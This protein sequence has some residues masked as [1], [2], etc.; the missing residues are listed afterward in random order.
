VVEDVDGAALPPPPESHAEHASTS[1]VSD[2]RRM[3]VRLPIGA[4]NMPGDKARVSSQS[5]S[6]TVRVEP[7]SKDVRRAIGVATGRKQWFGTLVMLL[8]LAGAIAIGAVLFGPAGPLIGALAFGACF[9]S[10]IL[11]SRRKMKRQ[12]ERARRGLTYTVDASGLRSETPDARAEF[13]W[14]SFRSAQLTD[15]H[16][17]LKLA[18]SG[19]VIYVPRRCFES[20]EA[21]STFIDI[22]SE[23][24]PVK[25][26]GKPDL[27]PMPPESETR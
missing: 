23:H 24:L 25:G 8:A 16:L 5:M 9:F 17:Y 10:M 11:W 4:K 2:T 19:S 26:L 18:G 12:A 15:E 21:E 6:A 22:V 20:P 1:A 27:T 7:T 13:A 14:S 3:D